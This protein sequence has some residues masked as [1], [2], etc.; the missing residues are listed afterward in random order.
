[1]WDFKDCRLGGKEKFSGSNQVPESRI[2]R[3]ER[4]DSWKCL[5]LL[6]QTVNGRKWFC[7]LWQN[8]NY[9]N[10]MDINN[11]NIIGDTAL[12]TPSQCAL[13]KDFLQSNLGNL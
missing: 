7:S 12:Q 11:K 9:N 4:L 6:K 3:Y 1:M 10:K 2:S 5:N 8:R 13:R